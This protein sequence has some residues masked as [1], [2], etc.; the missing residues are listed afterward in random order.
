MRRALLE[1]F[2]ASHG[3]KQIAGMQKQHVAAILSTQKPFAA[4]NWLK[5]LRGLMRFAVEIGLRPD[6]PTDGIKPAKAREGRIHTWSEAEI[7][8]FEAR[9]PIGSR[10][11]L[12]MELLLY[13]GQRRSDVVRMGPQHVRN[14]VLAVRQQKTGT[15]LMIPVH[16]GLAAIIAASECGH[17]TFLVTA[18]GAP[19]SSAGFGNL[20]R[21]WCSQAGLPQCSAH[22]L[23]KAACRRLAEI[24]C[25]APQIAAISG[26]KSLREVQRYIEEVNQARLAK[27]AISRLERPENIGV[28][29]LDAESV[30]PSGNPL[31]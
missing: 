2:R 9:H 10:A 25:T 15:A 12:A 4:R 11:R 13:T 24:G 26:H 19:F 18:A 28:S 1:R 16:S 31:I 14:G 23:R 17:L 8:Q 22:G 3:G 29:N 27:A 5:A 7:A 6:D 30:K 21:E 20:F